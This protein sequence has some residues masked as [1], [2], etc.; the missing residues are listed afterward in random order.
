MILSDFD[1]DPCSL[2]ILI[3]GWETHNMYPVSYIAD[4]LRI[5]ELGCKV[6]FGPF[7]YNFKTTLDQG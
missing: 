4:Q 1:G 5:G 3:T 6:M 7:F 2:I